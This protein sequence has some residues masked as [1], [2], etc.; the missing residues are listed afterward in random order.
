MKIRQLGAPLTVFDLAAVGA[1]GFREWAT[2]EPFAPGCTSEIESTTDGVIVPGYDALNRAWLASSLLLLK[3]YVRHIPLACSTYTWRT[4]AG[5]QERTAPTFRQQMAEEGV[6]AAVFSPRRMLPRFEGQLL[7]HHLKM[8]II[9]DAHSDVLDNIDASWIY[10]NYEKFN[11]LAADCPSFRFALESATDWRFAGN[12]RNAIARIW[13]GIEAI[14]GI[15]SELV[16]RVSL[17]SASLL[18]QR[19]EERLRRFTEVKKLYGIR[20]KAI[21]GD[22]LPDE[23]LEVGLSGSFKLLRELLIRIVDLGHPLNEKDFENAI[24]F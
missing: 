3:G 10:T 23:K 2:L 17:L 7:E 14:F 8:L 12:M 11:A 13:A 16:Y 19:G 15:S 9:P 6:N 21:H 18:A 20:S 22:A 1:A 4:I 24:F 5:Y